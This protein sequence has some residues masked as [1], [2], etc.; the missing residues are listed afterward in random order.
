VGDTRIESLIALYNSGDDRLM[1]NAIEQFEQ[2]RIP[3]GITASRYPSAQA[4]YIPPFSLWWV[5]MVHD[6]WLHRGDAAF[7]RSFLPGVRGV[8]GW[9]ARHVDETG[10][11]GPMPWWNF[12]DWSPAWERGVPPGAED[13]N[14]TALT[15]QYAYAL[16]RAADLEEVLGEPAQAAGYREQ[17]RRLI[18]SARATAWDAERGL[19]ADM[20]GKPLFSQHTNAL[21][22]LAGAVPQAEAR[23]VMERVLWEPDLV[24]AS[25]YFR[26]YIDEAMG[27]AGLAG[28]YLERLEP[29][30]EMV[31][32][33]LTTTPENPEPARSDSHAWSA[34][35]NYHLLASVLGIRPTAP[36]FARVRIAPALGPMQRAGGRMPHAAGT[37]EVQ[38]RRR[39]GGGIVG[40]IILP[41]RVSGEFRWGQRSVTLRPGPQRVTL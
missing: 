6:H 22:V 18:A 36:G 13:G 37:I 31:R 19:Y 39:G 23:A 41:P 30:S 28:R 27:Q 7:A 5:A 2:S 11:L 17:S 25:F 38:L 24:Q 16:N 15:F 34:H 4:Q 1:R 20:P 10:M 33:G 21:A 40:E 12:L 3:E 32:M 29:W 9:Y 26:F 35:P 14:S 8:L